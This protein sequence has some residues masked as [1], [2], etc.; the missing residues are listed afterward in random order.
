MGTPNPAVERV[1]GAIGGA[2]QAGL[3]IWG[4]TATDGVLAVG[5]GV[6]GGLAVLG[7]IIRIAK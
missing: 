1:S 5:L 2:T 6:F 3:M 7:T 4:S